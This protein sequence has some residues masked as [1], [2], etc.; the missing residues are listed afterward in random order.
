MYEDYGITILCLKKEQLLL[1]TN[2][3][4]KTRLWTLSVSVRNSY[5]SS[6]IKHFI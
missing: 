6:K 5:L 2:Y 4:Y 1:N 3:Q